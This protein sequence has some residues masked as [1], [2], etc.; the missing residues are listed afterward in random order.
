MLDF[1]TQSLEPEVE[2][3]NSLQK[4]QE[5]TENQ[6]KPTLTQSLMIQILESLDVCQSGW[7]ELMVGLLRRQE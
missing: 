6:D 1:T 2:R 4:I 7:M 5:M 3:L